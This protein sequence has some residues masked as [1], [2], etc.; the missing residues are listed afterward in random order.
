MKRNLGALLLILFFFLLIVGV[1]FVF[2][3]E[4]QENKENE[5]FGNR[6]SY[7]STPYGTM[8]YYTLLEESGYEVTRLERPFTTLKDRS[9]IGTL[10][11]IS[12]PPLSNPNEE[13]FTALNQWVESGKHL[14][15]I[16]REIAVEIGKMTAETGSSFGESNP[17]SLQPT[18]YSRG[19]ESL[20]VS[21]YASRVKIEKG[22]ATYLIG[23]DKGAILADAEVGKG[24]VVMLTDP[25]IVANNGIDKGDN[26][27]L[28][29][30]LLVNSP[31]GK[32]AF[33]EYH[34]G[35]GS[36]GD[37]GSALAYFNGTPVKWIYWQA[38]LITGLLVYTYGRRF[39]R[40]IP[41]RRERRTT[42]LEFVSSMANITRLAKASDLAMQNIYSDFHSK[43]CRYGGVPTRVELPRLAAVVAR[44]M[45][46]DERELKTLLEKCESVAQG[47]PTSDSELL[48]LV[49]R[50]REIEREIRV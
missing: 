45:R 29:I 3:N 47:E 6:S 10:V 40:P 24:R 20:K 38:L 43:L 2:M 37:D 17:Q 13:E 1:N 48:K 4:E 32:I 15:I 44:R 22:A 11:L 33:D 14:I 28:A 23:D 7:R 8:A 21:K 31:P 27:A 39:A 35:Y 34:H 5:Q 36:T 50:I 49:T 18:L 25:F 26:V 19:V 41:L 9:D 12:L 42:N 30:N 46:G 16:D